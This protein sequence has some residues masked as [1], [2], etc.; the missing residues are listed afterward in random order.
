MFE[1]AF[2][3]TALAAVSAYI[4]VNLCLIMAG[5]R[6]RTPRE[7]LVAY[8]VCAVVA[9]SA[10]PA[11]N[12]DRGMPDYSQVWVLATGVAIACMTH[13]ARVAAKRGRRFA[14]AY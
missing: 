9:I 14:G 13:L 4:A 11:I 10:A 8:A 5:A 7:T 2:G 12:A 1:G 6:L 3:T